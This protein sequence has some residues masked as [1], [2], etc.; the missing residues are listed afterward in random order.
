MY[1]PP[2]AARKAAG[3]MTRRNKRPFPTPY[4]HTHTHTHT[5]T[6]IH[7]RVHIAIHTYTYAYI[8]HIH[9]RVHITHTHTRTYAIHTYTYT[10]TY[11][12]ISLQRDVSYVYTAM[13]SEERCRSQD[14]DISAPI[15]NAETSSPTSP[16]CA[17]FVWVVVAQQDV[18]L[19]EWSAE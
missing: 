17:V 4:T 8:S 16:F 3:R 5:R 9:I 1:I 2:C 15:P 12:Y 19:E 7:I 13:C 10:Y 6:H 14:T 18:R 11:A